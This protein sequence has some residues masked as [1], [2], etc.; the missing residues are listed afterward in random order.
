MA[1]RGHYQH[2]DQQKG[3]SEVTQD[4]L[5]DTFTGSWVPD[6]GDEDSGSEED[7]TEDATEDVTVVTG[8]NNGDSIRAD[9]P[10]GAAINPTDI[11]HE[12]TNIAYA[13]IRGSCYWP[14]SIHQKL[15]SSSVINFL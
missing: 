10:C 4:V 1:Q 12:A 9:V 14:Q 8:E 3:S 6:A 15:K 5:T 13:N 11:Q 7:V 2:L